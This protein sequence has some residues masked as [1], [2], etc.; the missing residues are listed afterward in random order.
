MATSR[1]CR[2]EQSHA[3]EEATEQHGL[4]SKALEASDQQKNP[5]WKRYSRH[6]D[7]ERDKDHGKNMTEQKVEVRLDEFHVTVVTLVPSLI[8]DYDAARDVSTSR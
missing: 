3:R 4:R 8:Q 2:G 5:T 1:E 6:L 7:E